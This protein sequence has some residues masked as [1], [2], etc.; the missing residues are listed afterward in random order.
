MANPE[1]EKNT[2]ELLE[3]KHKPTDRLPGCQNHRHNSYT[4][5]RHQVGGNH[6]KHTTTHMLHSSA[7]AFIGRRDRRFTPVTTR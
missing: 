5:H 6:G 2:H 7:Y 4:D 1:L 3:R